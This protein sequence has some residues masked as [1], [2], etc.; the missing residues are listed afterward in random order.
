MLYGSCCFF[1]QSLP[2]GSLFKTAVS[3]RKRE[4]MKISKKIQDIN[5]RMRCIENL[6]LSRGRC[7]DIT[8][9]PEVVPGSNSY[10][11]WNNKTSIFHKLSEV[12]VAN[13]NAVMP[14]ICS[15]ASLE[16]KEEEEGIE[17]SEETSTKQ[18]TKC[19]F[20]QPTLPLPLIYYPSVWNILT[21]GGGAGGCS[22][23]TTLSWLFLVT[24]IRKL[25]SN[26]SVRASHAWKL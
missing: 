10:L 26:V 4:N 5:V 15:T 12:V 23:H 22:W 7:C 24:G 17:Q 8:V 9:N 11:G 13:A 25:Y 3:L 19:Y 18:G 16:K 21:N 1:F 6:V 2:E 20:S 14:E